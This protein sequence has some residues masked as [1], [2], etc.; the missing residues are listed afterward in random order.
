V[1]DHHTVFVLIHL[2]RA[3]LVTLL[4]LLRFGYPVHTAPPADDSFN[5][6]RAASPTDREQALFGLG[7]GDAGQRPDLGVR[8]LSVCE[9]LGQPRQRPERACDAHALPSGAGIKSDTPRQP[10][11]ARAEPV[12]PAVA[13]V[14]LTDEVEEVRGGRVEMRGQLRNLVAEPVQFRRKRNHAELPPA[15]A[16]LHPDFGG[17][18]ERRG[19]KLPAGK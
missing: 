10:R 7:R 15:A 11:R 12:V 14:E 19:R 17:S 5:V 8:K 16:T 13:S 2:K 1:D 4:G 3:A 18:W 9:G 6:R